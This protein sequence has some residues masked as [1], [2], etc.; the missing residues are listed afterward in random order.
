M[1][2]SSRLVGRVVFGALYV[3][4][5]AVLVATAGL[6]ADAAFGFRMFPESSTMEVHLARRVDAPSGH[7]TVLVDVEDGTWTTKD[8]SGLPHV[9]RWRDRVKEPELGIFDAM[10]HASYGIGTQ[11]SRLAAALDYVTDHLSEDAETRTLVLAV[12]YKKNGHDPLKTELE[13]AL[14]SYRTGVEP[15]P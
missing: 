4:T 10:H 5:Q 14:P 7:G 13:S 11:L 1:W 12:T 8:R 9:V 15:R 3:G 2:P 6:R